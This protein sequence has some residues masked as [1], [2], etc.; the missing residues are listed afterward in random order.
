MGL[1]YA[2]DLQP[3][4]KPCL[5]M[6]QPGRHWLQLFPRLWPAR[7][8][9]YGFAHHSCA[10]AALECTDAVHSSEHQVTRLVVLAAGDF[11]SCRQVLS[12]C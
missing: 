7:A 10:G 2:Q 4:Q 6:G 9:G 3:M 11:D 8:T 12:A 5:K 1:W